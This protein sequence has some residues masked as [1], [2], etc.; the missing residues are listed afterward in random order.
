MPENGDEQK[1]QHRLG[2]INRW[3]PPEDHWAS[4]Y[5]W[6]RYRGPDP[7]PVPGG[8]VFNDPEGGGHWQYY[9][10]AGVGHDDDNSILDE[11][12]ADDAVDDP[13]DQLDEQ[14]G[15]RAGVSVETA[16]PDE[17]SMRNPEDE[18]LEWSLE[19]AGTEVFRRV[20]PDR[21]DLMAAVAEALAAYHDGDLDERVDEITPA[22]GRVPDD[23]REQEELEQREEEN[24]SLDEF[25]TD[26]GQIVHPSTGYELPEQ[27]D[28]DRD[29]LKA[30]DDAL[31]NLFEAASEAGGEYYA[32]IAA[33]ELGA[34]RAGGRHR[35]VVDG[36]EQD[37]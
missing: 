33:S 25:V 36:G 11:L 7:W 29:E 18:E 30:I 2:T 24:E 9:G 22:T 3:D 10:D 13:Y 21:S 34:F 26:G 35:A 12:K 14:R 28:Y 17:V 8:W 32:I 23:V 6:T 15:R 27:P 19:V 20:E 4:K 16:N 31:V 5:H 37:E 1:E